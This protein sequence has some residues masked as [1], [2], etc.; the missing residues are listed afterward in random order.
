MQFL[1]QG[2]YI[3][4]L[5]GKLSI[6]GFLLM[7]SVAKF[8]KSQIQQESAMIR[9]NKRLMM[10]IKVPYQELSREAAG[11]DSGSELLTSVTRGHHAALCP[12]PAS[13]ADAKLF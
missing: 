12:V 13:V 9:Y 1:D 8:D 11:G 5:Q 4:R 7:G 2:I 3:W 10:S 6:L